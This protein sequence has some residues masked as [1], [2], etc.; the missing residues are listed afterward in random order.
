MSA[1]FLK[2]PSLFRRIFEKYIE[3]LDLMNG[4]DKRFKNSLQLNVFHEKD[5][6]ISSISQGCTYKS[7]D[8]QSIGTLN[9]LMKMTVRLLTHAA[10]ESAIFFKPLHLKC[11][12]SV[13]K[14]F[15]IA[16]LAI[17]TLCLRYFTGLS[18]RVRKTDI[19]F[20][21][22]LIG[23]LEGIADIESQLKMWIHHGKMKSEDIAKYIQSA[24]E[25]IESGVSA[26]LADND[27][28]ASIIS[29]SFRIIS[30]HLKLK[31]PGYDEIVRSAYKL[32]KLA[33]PVADNNNC[34]AQICQ[35]IQESQN[36]VD[37]FTQSVSLLVHVNGKEAT[38]VWSLIEKQT[39]S[40]TKT[41]SSVAVV[42][43]NVKC[44]SVIF[45]CVRNIENKIKIEEQQEKCKQ[46]DALHENV[47]AELTKIGT[48]I[49][50]LKAQKFGFGNFESLIGK[51]LK[52]F[53]H[54]LKEES[55]VMD[56]KTLFLISELAMMALS[57][58]T[59]NDMDEYVQLLIML[60][61]LSP[62]VQFSEL[63]HDHFQQ[64]FDPPTDR[65]GNLFGSQS[66]SRRDSVDTKLEALKMVRSIEAGYL[67]SKNREI[68][69]DFV[70]QI[71]ESMN[72]PQY[73][74]IL[75][76]IVISAAIQ[77]A[78]NLNNFNCLVRSSACNRDTQLAFSAHLK[79]ILCLSFGSC[80]VFKVTR[81]NRISY[82]IACHHCDGIGG[83]SG[84]SENGK[85][86]S[87]LIEKHNG[88]YVRRP[89]KAIEFDEELTMA[90]FQLFA[91]R[92]ATVRNNMIECIPSLLVH[93]DR[94]CF[95]K[96]YVDLWLKPVIDDDPANRISM[97]RQIGC[98][99]KALFV[100]SL[101][102]IEHFKINR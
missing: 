40:L 54:V 56:R 91:S 97:S 22:H 93:L 98:V 86:Y 67:T 73:R 38:D 31:I 79:T 75:L 2:Q 27:C 82:E 92:D 62:F 52:L 37:D 11:A 9:E 85:Y 60:F 33:L 42:E 23:M 20:Q 19:E 30:T 59:S 24:S 84:E 47:S 16:P 94:N 95:E 96:R 99:Q 4:C 65:I 26:K 61:A 28:I 72:A 35:L 1:S 64:A 10:A 78:F 58:S 87:D 29:A 89:N 57:L 76:E 44:L 100:S 21:D 3:L 74:N 17:K 69:M 5:F 81:A 6:D 45:Q 41:E 18:H 48:D 50:T 43:Q 13:S 101:E 15:H 32:L 51:I 36:N 49:S 70:M 90:T 8:I 14:A 88:K 34:S 39:E 12:Q 53:N 71:A 102:I 68:L 25:L 46:L 63:L 7:I 83:K 55:I 80:A 77:D 66:H